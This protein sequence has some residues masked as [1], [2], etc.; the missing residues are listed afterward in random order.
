S[1]R[2]RQN[3]GTDS[4]RDPQRLSRLH[5]DSCRVQPSSRSCSRCTYF[6]RR[7]GW[8]VHRR[9]ILSRPIAKP[10]TS[11]R[12]VVLCTRDD[13]G[14]RG[15][16]LKFVLCATRVRRPF[17]FPGDRSASCAT[18]SLRKKLLLKILQAL[19]SYPSGTLDI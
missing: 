17:V 8:L 11:R 7:D 2:R 12:L 4:Q 3:P 16:S 19:P 6:E 14:T 15:A 9:H 1:H 5:H 10:A 18:L 13:G